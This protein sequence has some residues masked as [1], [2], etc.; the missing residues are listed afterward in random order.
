MANVHRYA[1]DIVILPAVMLDKTGSRLLDGVTPAE[2]ELHLGK[3]V[4]FASY[5]SEV[6]RIVFEEAVGT[7]CQT[8]R[9]QQALA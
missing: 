7:M 4:Y 8:E 6:D 5:L 3:R 2:L 1:G 9:W